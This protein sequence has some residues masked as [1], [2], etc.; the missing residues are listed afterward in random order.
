MMDRGVVSI[1]PGTRNLAMCWL[2]YNSAHPPPQSM[3]EFLGRI[4]LLRFSFV[5]LN[6]THIE[7]AAV[8]FAQQVKKG[9]L[10]WL[11]EEARNYDVVIER[12]VSSAQRARSFRAGLT[13]S[14]GFSE[15]SNHVSLSRVSG[16]LSGLPGKLSA[17]RSILPSEAAC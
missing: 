3:E 17:L 6:T 13:P 8:A 12:Q 9:E 4:S 1:D 2:G 5:D 11:W 7:S 10:S 16:L 15:Q 14:V